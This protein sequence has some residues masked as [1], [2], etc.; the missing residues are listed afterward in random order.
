[1]TEREFQKLLI[2]TQGVFESSIDF[3]R[4]TLDQ[5]IWLKDGDRFTIQPDVKETIFKYLR[6]YPRKDLLDIAQDI[7][8]V[9]SIGTNQYDDA[10]D[11]DV[12]IVP[13]KTSGV[14]GDE[15]FQKEVKT[16]FDER[17]LKI[18]GHPFEVYIQSDPTQ[19]LLSDAC[20]DLLS[21]EWK[22]GPKIVSQDYDPMEDF[23]EVLSQVHSTLG[24]ADVSLGQLKREVIDFEV[25]KKALTHMK[26]EQKQVLMKKLQA[27]LQSIE[28]LI[29]DLYSKRKEWV[30]LRR[31]ASKPKSVEQ[32]RNDVALV[33]NW[34]D[35]NALFKFIGRYN[36]MRVIGELQKLLK[37]DGNITS[38][39]VDDVDKIVK[40]I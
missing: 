31:E 13:K 21:D 19:D 25:I 4:E 3:P 1:M 36:Y 17:G 10:A 23:S 2:F 38:D 12:H 15:A 9:G 20:Y 40:D 33:K 30:E 37:D 22:S 16:W 14:F 24:G 11:V 7:N 34:K 28:D 29:H 39:E 35:K 26:P 18:S 27:K 32:A 5:N 8:I 6:E